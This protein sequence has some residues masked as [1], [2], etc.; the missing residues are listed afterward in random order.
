MRRTATLIAVLFASL[1]LAQTPPPEVE[2]IDGFQAYGTQAN[3][4]GWIDN[5][6][7]QPR[8]EAQGLYKTWPDPI[9]KKNPNV[10]YGTKQSSGKPEGS[11]PRIGTFSTHAP[12]TFS[13]RGRF[14]YRGRL[15]RTSDDTR[16]GLTF[17]SS[18]P[19]SDS[20]YLIGLWSTPAGKLTMQLFGFGAGSISG[21]VDSNVS[22]DV[23]KWY[24]FVIE[25]D[26]ADNSTKIRARFWP[27]G[28]TEPQTFSIDAVDAASSRLTSGRIGIWSA[29]KGEAYVDDLFAK[30]PVD[31]TAPLISILESGTPL[32]D[33]TVF[34]RDATPE[35]KVT[36]DLSA[37]NFTATL[38]GA[39]YTSLTPVTT[40]RWH[41]LLV[42]ASDSAGNA[43]ETERKF[44]VDKTPPVVS[45]LESGNA[46]PANFYFN[47]D[48]VIT[49]TVVD[50]SN[51]V[52]SATIDGQPYTPGLAYGIEG[53]HQLS[54]TAVDEAG[55]TT[56][57]G[58]F[59]FTIDKTAPVLTFTSH[60]NGAV[61]T[62][63]QAIV[64]GGSDDAVTVTLGGTPATVDATAKT[65]TGPVALLEGANT[66]V[67]TGTDRAGNTGTATLSLAVDT[68]APE[69]TITTPAADACVDA[70]TITVSGTV[71]EGR[72]DFVRVNGVNA[73][74][75]GGAWTASIP[76]TEGKLLIT[77]EARDTTGHTASRSRG[78]IVD[79]TAP[80]I[81]V[82]AGGAPFT[83]TLTNRAVSLFVRATD[84]DPNVTVTATLDG[85]A[86]T[87]G[88]SVDGEGAHK[89]VVKATDC[90]GHATEKTVEFTIDLT[91]PSIREFQPANGGTV[92]TTPNA[93]AAKTDTDVATVTVDATS[94]S[95][96]PGA[97]G[98]FTIAGVPFAE[99]TNRFTL[100][101]T[102][103]AG[104]SASVAYSVVVRTNAPAVEIRESGLPIVN[105]TLYNRAITPVLRAMPDAP[106]RAT[107]N[108]A[109][110]TSGTTITADGEYRI[111]ATAT[112]NLGHSG[113]A[114]ATFTIDRTPPAVTIASPAN[115]AVIRSDRVE[116]RGT[117][118]GA[119]AATINGAP[120]TIG[121][122]GSFAV[123]LPLDYGAN[124][125]F[126]AARDAAGNNGRADVTVL[127]DDAGAG[128][129][130]TYPADRSITNRRSTDVAGRLLTAGR[131]TTVTIGTQSVPVDAPGGFRLTGYALTEGENTIT[132]TA[133]ASNGL[134]TSA[135]THVTADFTPPSL[136]ILESSQPLSDG[137]RF[138]TRAAISL[139]ASDAGGSV[140]TELTIDGTVAAAPSS[141]TA[142]GGH[143]VV[144]TARD[145]AGNQS[146]AERMFFIGAATATADCKLEGFD[147]T[148]NA[149]VLSSS[150]TIVGRS[151]G[152]I[153]VKANGVP[154]VVADG[155]F[156]ATVELPNE[157]TNVVTVNCTD[158]NGTPTG[159]PA[160]LTLQRV[161]GDPSININT[162]AEGF[163]TSQ[164]TIAVSGTVGPGVTSAD[165][166]GVAA[167]ITGT[168]FT[169]PT[170]RLA[171]G[172]NII[173]A[174]GR[175]AAGRTAT[176]SR[177]GVYEKDAPSIAISTPTANA[178]TGVNRITVSGTY[179][180]IDPASIV[181]TNLSGNQTRPANAERFSDT[182]GAF[183]AIDVPLSSGDQTL[184]VSG[185]DRLNREATATVVVKLVAGSPGIS[186]TSPASQSWF[187]PGSNTFTV[188]GTF[189]AEAGALVDVN[190]NGATISGSSYTATATFSPVSGATTPV[191]A[192]VT[193]P[194]GTSAATVI[195]VTRLNDAPKV[196]E[197]FPAQNATEVDAGA[198]LLVLFS[199]P[200][201]VA[202]LSGGFRLED[203]NGAPVS[204]S[205]YLD[206]DVLTFA[207]STLLA[208]GGRYTMRVNG[209]AKNLAGTAVAEAYASSFTVASSAPSTPPNVDPV[210][211]AVCGQS[212]SVTGTAAPGA[213]VRLE[214]GTLVLTTSADSHGRFTF[215]YPMSGQSGFTVVRVRVVG[216]DGS[217][218]PAAEL[219][220]RVD[221]SGPQVLN[222][223]FDRT[224]N[225]LTISFSEA[226]DASTV[227]VGGA[228]IVLTLGDGTTVAGTTSVAG[229]S[230]TV[231]PASDLTQ[232]AFTLTVGTQIEDTTGNKLT[233]PYTQEFT[234]AGGQPETGDGSGF[235]SGEVYDATTGRPLPGVTIAVDVA[236]PAPVTTTTDARGRYLARLPEGAHTI[237]AAHAGYTSVFRE[238]IV[239]AGAGV[240]P[241]DIRL[242]HRGPSQTSTGA[243]LALTHGGD[244]GIT[245]K[246]DLAVPSA[247]SGAK[248]TLT[249]ISAQALTG[250]LPLGWSPI[251]SAEVQLEN[252]PSLSA[253]TLT[254]HTPAGAV[255]SAA[256]NLTAVHYD[257][258]RDEWRVLASSVNV[259][260]DGR[261]SFPIPG[262]GA[263]AL[264]YSDK[265]PGLTPPPLPVVGD[266]LQG[267]P[268]AP[269][270]APEL[271]ERD[272]KLDPAIVVPT[273]RTVATLRI[274]GAGEA[275]FPSGTAVQA[276]IDEELRLADGSRL[277]D[278]P[279]AT[280]LLLYRNLSGDLGIADF[281]LAPSAKAAQVILEVGFDHI[282]ILPYPGRLDRGTLI[283]SEGGRVPADDK[284]AIEIPTGAVPEPLRATATSLNASDLAAVGNIAGFRVVGGFQLTLQRAVQPAP[285]DLDGDGQPDAIAGVE[286]FVPARA[287]FSVDAAKMPAPNAQVILAE[288]LDQT[289]YGRIVRLA[290]PMM[291]VDPSQ[292]AT[293]AIRFTTR[294]ID[295]SA[296]PVDGVVREGRYIVLAADAPIAFATGTVRMRDLTGRLLSDARVI[297]NPLGVHELTRTNGIYNVPV[298]A[299]P[300]AP[301]TLVPRHTTTGDGATYT[302]AAQV[303][304]DA[305]VRVDLLLVPQPPVLGNVTIFKG[306]PPSQ[307]ALTFGTVTRDVAL[308]TNI[309]AAF[310]PAIDPASV[311]N[312]SITVVNAIT[313]KTVSGRA[314]SEGTTGVIWTLTA[315]ERFEPN[316]AYSVVI[317]QSI[318]GTNGATLA[319]SASF[320][321]AT[322]A[323]FVNTQIRRER[324]RIT[325]PNEAGISRITGDAGALPA[326]WQ[327]V[328]TRRVRDFFVR[329]Q[330]TA[331]SDGS[332]SFLIGD[333]DVRDR[334]TTGD[335]IDLQV[336]NTN[337][338]LAGIYALTP[339]VT[340]DGKGF[341][342]PAGAAVTFTSPEGITVN[343][344]EGAFD[345]P[346]IVTVNSAQKAEFLDIPE[347]EAENN[348][349]TSV[350]I[351]FEGFAN[352]PL[353]VEVAVP[354]GLNTTGRD[355]ILAWKGMSVRGPRLAVVD[356]MQVKDGKFTTVLDEETQNAKIG[357]TNLKTGT[358]STLVGRQARDYMLRLIRGGRYMV[359]DIKVPVGGSVGWGVMEG[360]QTGYDLM[361]DI[362]WSYYDPYVHNFERGGRIIPVITGR[363]FTV[364]GIDRATG[365]QAFQRAYDPIPVGEPGEIATIPTPQQNDSG[366][367]P[368]FGSPFRVEILDLD[369][370]DIEIRTVR[371]FSVTVAND[372]VVVSPSDDP[373]DSELHVQLLNVKQGTSVSGTAGG[374]L[375]IGAKLGDRIVLLIE[376][377]DVDASHPV[378]IVLNEAIF[379]GENPS[380]DGAVDAFLHTQLKLE[381]A[382]EPASGGQPNYTDITAHARFTVDSGEKRINII[383]PG[384]LQREAVYRLTLKGTLTDATTEGAG[385]KLGAGTVP[386]ANNNLVAV[387]GGAD[388]PLIFHV[389]KPEGEIGSFMAADTG[390]IRG[391]AMHGNA[392][393]VAALDGGLRTFDMSNPAAINGTAPQLSHIGPPNT[394]YK[395]MAVQVDRH[396]RVVTTADLNIVGVMLTY[397]VEDLVAGA[398][399]QQ[400]KASS[401][402][403]WKLGYSSMIGLPSNTILSDR[404]ESIPFRVK[405]VNQDD[406]TDFAD[407]QLFV[408]GTGASETADF[409]IE[410][411]KSY[412]VTVPFSNDTYNYQRITIENPDLDMSWS[413]DA[414][415]GGSATLKN[416]LA[417]PTDKLR[418]VKNRRAYA[419]VAHLGYGVGVYDINAMESNRY[420]GTTQANRYKEQH[421]LGNG[422]VGRECGIEPPIW[423]IGENY[424]N[425]DVEV[426]G[427]PSGDLYIFA[428]HPSK[429]VLDYRVHLSGSAAGTPS[430]DATCDQ[431]GET[432]LLFRTFPPGNEAP[433]MQALRN[434]I[435][436]PNMHTMSM[437]QVHWSVTA[438]ENTRGIRGT[439]RDLPA[440]RDY[441]LVAALDYGIVVVET[442]GDPFFTP[443]FPLD[444]YHI[445]DVIWIPGGAVGLR[446]MQDSNTA[447]VTDKNGRVLLVDLSRIDERFDADGNYVEGLF[448]TAAKAIAGTP[449]DP[450]EIG[451]DD[452][453]IIWKSEPGLT[454]GSQ[455][456]IFDASTGIIYGANMAARVVKA[457]SAVDPVVKMK[458]N[459]GNGL[460]EV[461]GVIPLGV[462]IPD[463]LKTTIDGL[464]AGKPAPCK[465][466]ASMGAFRLEVGLPG[467]LLNS[468]PNNE[469]WMA[470]ESERIAGAITEQTPNGFPRAHLRRKRRDGTSE[471]GDR[472]ATNFKFKR[473]VPDALASQLK[474][475]RGYNRYM[476][477]W[478]VAV[479]DPRASEQYNWNGASKE[480]K[481][482]AGCYACERPEFLK[483]KTESDGIY[484]LYT[485][486]R[487]L[488]VRPELAG[489]GDDTV[490][491]G[492]EY[493]YLGKQKRMSGLFTTIMADT[494]RPTE[495]LTAGQN[496]PVATGMIAETIFLHSG[497]LHSATTDLNVGGRAGTELLVERTYRSRTMG[498]SVF[499]QGWD[500]A[501]LRRLRAL[502]NGDVE[503]R[504]GSDVWTFK[505]VNGDY[506]APEGLFL[507]LARTGRGW[508]IIDQ[509][510]RVTDFDDLGRIT[511][512]TDEFYDPSAPGSGN[513]IRYVY[514]ETGRLAQVVDPVQRATKFTYWKESEAGASG[515]FPGMIRQV[516]DWRDRK[517]DYEY[518]SA[519]GTLTKVKLAEVQNVSGGRPAVAY[520]YGPGGGGFNDVL[521]M[522][523]NLARITAPHEV[524]SG[525]GPRLEFTYDPSSGFK[526]DRLLAQKWGTGE[527]ASFNYNG[528]TSVSTTDTLGQ[529]RTYSLTQQ[530]TNPYADRAHILSITETAVRTSTAPFGQLPGSISPGVPPAGSQDRT[531]RFTY[532]PG[533]NYATA[534]LD[535]VRSTTFTWKNVEPEAPGYVMTG[536]NTTGGAAPPVAQTIAYQA[537]ANLATFISSMT[538]NGLKIDSPEP[539]RNNKNTS[540]NNDQIN[541]TEKFDASG[542]LTTIA[543]SGGTDAS[544][545]GSS[546][547]ITYAPATDSPHR[548]ALPTSIVDGGL[549][550]K[551]DYPS[552]TKTVETDARGTVT[553]IEYDKWQRPIHMSASGGIDEKWEYDA[554]GK[555]RKHTRKQG[556]DDVTTTYTYDIM[557]RQTSESVTG[558]ADVG[559]ATTTIQYNGRT[560][561]T[562][563][564]SGAVT[565]M[566]V[567][568]LGRPIGRELTTGGSP[569]VAHYTHDLEDNVVAESDLLTATA[570]AY[571]AQGN[572]TGVLS[573]DG[574]RTVATIDAM[575]NPLTIE[576]RDASGSVLRSWTMQYAGG[577]LR[578]VTR[579]AGS[580]ST[581]MEVA[582]D[583]AGRT[584]GVSAG[585][586]AQRTE[587]DA[588]GRVQS[589]A[590]GA[591][592]AT[593]I[594]QIFEQAQA[595][596]HSGRLPQK[597]Q[598]TEKGGGSYSMAMQYNT[599]GEAV[600]Q[601]LGSLSWTKQY[602]QMGNVTASSSPQR[603]THTY[604]YDSQG[605]M[606][607]ETLPGGA[608]TTFGYNAAGTMNSYT[609]PSSEV[610]A[611]QTDLIGRATQRTYRDGTTE[612]IVWE[613]SRVK[614]ITDRQGRLQTFEYNAKGQIERTTGGSGVVLD[615][616]TYDPAGRIT[617]WKTPDAVV[618]YD[619]YDGE[620]RAGKTTQSRYRGGT[621][622]DQYEQRHTYNE[623]GER[624]SFTMPTYSGFSSANAWTRSVTQQHDAMGNLIGIERQMSGGA[625]SGSLLQA[626][627]RNANRPD[628]RVVTTV[629]GS[630]IVR[631]Y[632]Y[633]S[634]TGLPNK[635]EVKSGGLT[636]AGSFVTWDGIQ[637]S[638]A[639]L[640]GVSGG[641]RAD[642]WTYDGRGRLTATSL[643]RDGGSTPDGADLNSADFRSAL[644]RTKTTPVDPPSLL[645]SEAPGHKIASMQRGS[646]AEAFSFNGG[647]RSEDGQF[648]YEYDLK[649]RLSV[650]T[651]KSASPRR[652][653]YFY[654]G[655]DRMV[656]RRAEYA[657]ATS[658]PTETDWKLE[659]RFE[660][661][662]ADALPPDA[663]FV[664]DPVDDQLVAIYKAGASQNPQ[665][666]E[667]GGLVRQI[668]HGGAR[669]DDPLEVA[670]A[671]G[672]APNGVARLYPIYDEGGAG[673][674]DAILNEQG[675]IVSRSVEG[676]PYGEDEAVLKGSAVDRVSV[677]ARR[678]PDGKITA[679]DVLLRS[680]EH[681][682]PSTL[683]AG[684]RLA[685]IDAAGKVVRAATNA[686]SLINSA[687]VQWSLTE[688]EWNTLVSTEPVVVDGQ[689][690]TPSALSI[691]VTKD[692][693]AEAWSSA[694]PFLAAPAW[695]VATKPV[696]T[697][698][699]LPLE[700]RESLANLSQ[701]LAALPADEQQTTALY[702]V[703]SLYAL[704]TPRMAGSPI[705][706]PVTLIVSS[707]FHA[708]PFLDPMTG[709]SYVRARW[710][711]PRTGTW[712]TPDPR[713]Y[714]D[715]P[716]LYAYA[717]NDPINKNDPTGEAWGFAVD[718]A[719]A[720][721]D[722]YQYA[723]GGIDGKEYAMRMALT[724]ASVLAN[725]ATGGMGGGVLV[726]A[727]SMAGRAGR[728]VR[729]VLR[730]SVIVNRVD[731]AVTVAQ[732]AIS[733]HEAVV[734]GDY[735][736]GGVSAAQLALTALGAKRGRNVRGQA[737]SNRTPAAA[738]N[739]GE[740][741]AGKIERARNAQL[742]PG[743]GG[744]DKYRITRLK[745]G[746]L[747][748]G[749]FPGQGQWYTD[750]AT[751]K[752]S[753]LNQKDYHD[754]VQVDMRPGKYPPR[755]RI[756]AY[757][758]KEDIEVPAGLTRANRQHGGGGGF[759]YFIESYADV[760]EP[761]RVFNMKK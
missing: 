176:A 152:A 601:T 459:L 596:G 191:V 166:N 476:S 61:L 327:A 624:T 737:V 107:L 179:T 697:S 730:A 310:T 296:L 121:D 540:A 744:Q 610:T 230:V 294:S 512:E 461:G 140:T 739:L 685:V 494:I 142:A 483:T 200:M 666:D 35:V 478:I 651:Q 45:A 600:A 692:A 755:D 710:F 649:G 252:A 295:R 104:N 141:V 584:T 592:S 578:S 33:G 551:L 39:P 165:V 158:A 117:V 202:S 375:S 175:N 188:T 384:A 568:S 535:G 426:R 678:D 688:A 275:K 587:F 316:T 129:I 22:V 239:P 505:Y 7:G 325:I 542:Q 217:L 632:G 89:L 608:S 8:P 255:T 410:D 429:G 3:P 171:D 382:P 593:S 363:P 400:S 514:D 511:L 544:S 77:V 256:Q 560:I 241:I 700:V 151:G 699:L 422:I 671:D 558:V 2:F 321:F 715:S 743:Y 390:V 582:W 38:N 26:D 139:D 105:G 672:T 623:H 43:S 70:A 597:M 635:M 262:A 599:L 423:A 661:I 131:G 315:G 652:V 418:I 244:T 266:V 636:V 10:V 250:L 15:L 240:I 282:R 201:D 447:V 53:T 625:G 380:D 521:E 193:E 308:T 124:A 659:D 414:T 591:G 449:S 633:D 126:I 9:D 356:M 21:T 520:E 108:G 759:Q 81:E 144:A 723:T 680:T 734:H 588:A 280:D 417:R 58:P 299:K 729:T 725:V 404:P 36:D 434:A 306:D 717:A 67:A 68:R 523:T 195:F 689:T 112:D 283:G 88:T 704:G 531:Y 342:A 5:S 662:A 411:L 130:L 577:R 211:S 29:V 691:A 554:T 378:S 328:A 728:V 314:A 424:I 643:A 457:V 492:T 277:L 24:R 614:S 677:S 428:N 273:G 376:Q 495:V 646:A 396:G 271:V 522:R 420:P 455:P 696:Y 351:D 161:T 694:Q 34:K 237:S 267:V 318:R 246:V 313:G 178:T 357:V 274:E 391:M 387:G 183:A 519:S 162:P 372:N 163:V 364:Y 331:A 180:N 543:G 687:T 322:V 285:Q 674:L 563:H 539:S 640:L 248:V 641:A 473:V 207:P 12:K 489:L 436:S 73:T 444:D 373:L 654:S 278:P 389:R 626:D 334:V 84:T 355:F 349:A 634:G 366:P 44:L 14:E 561:V 707:S 164:E 251:A 615:E 290:A 746:Q 87:S 245:R 145:R 553:T 581:T 446:V 631:D 189:T 106:V 748:Y 413:A 507:K 733:L 607:R 451:A 49:A 574:T 460:T 235:I 465:E 534:S 491:E 663:T 186:I 16:I 604:S 732:T 374:S 665:I 169:V 585:G 311:T 493:E 480:K 377:K 66:I 116:V 214:S 198:L 320:S 693:R 549:L 502:P 415:I 682:A 532:G 155:S 408:A 518:Q 482:E 37:V 756:Q 128:I 218:S 749:A 95:A 258:V 509:Q 416:V 212:M 222:A 409:P 210:G 323:V 621:L 172:L 742:Y 52:V 353:D 51:T 524:L 28:S 226:L 298:P 386:A 481:A 18:Y 190:G 432:G 503:Y 533:G 702:D 516:T 761:V 716:N 681:F 627:Y 317:S 545:A 639:Q 101:A 466:N 233:T 80:A 727:A 354:P 260:G 394:I 407:R 736:R 194:D 56:T 527:T 103:R 269:A 463:H 713:G 712:L 477:P 433:R 412:N 90:A 720:A 555:L 97:G 136:T 442:T 629:T 618:D 361:W 63:A 332:F 362:F 297:A 1:A 385:L 557:G 653:K 343:V 575:G 30:S 620:G 156:S 405:I 231:T 616:Y 281:H 541:E 196:V 673:S 42:R 203:A 431:R 648:I 606:K 146:R 718:I 91:A 346:T 547:T 74:V 4:P 751:I 259:A 583:G 303:D 398:T 326:G 506:K 655:D 174:H 468:M 393:M 714:V 75:T 754:L 441:L 137:A 586:R 504:D 234:L 456:P 119:V 265:A 638:R 173:V 11:N 552:A 153:G 305:V 181:V 686:P 13:A 706:N 302:H 430:N 132:A 443:P 177:R 261:A 656:G 133:T 472:A 589:T 370:E 538:A 445:A 341:V 160:T 556:S 168:T 47:R 550:T 40:E 59:T 264:V 185:R 257:A 69:L 487:Y 427:D 223:A 324:I 499:G 572:L 498:G 32:A 138:A 760:L 435:G 335:L 184:R 309:R 213:R 647:E 365:L 726:R 738:A 753:K 462:A 657:G 360:L 135:S 709:K 123:E 467:G 741:R 628:R 78:V 611:T 301:F 668:I 46:F 438:E 450:N 642:E 452:P 225:K 719:F 485:N 566:I 199:Q 293:P 690:L 115:D 276:Y 82:T 125:I 286:L 48:V 147:P 698:A 192:R 368:V 220:V 208:K 679:V 517:I 705:G 388:L 238:I 167:T 529:A 562:N 352:K 19:Q 86:Y 464:C 525:G 72:L 149:V 644:M 263:Y 454:A 576:E 62:A 224:V 54:L 703:P 96:T 669:Y 401:I 458:V 683:A 637:K 569:I 79:R 369:V 664:W 27:E 406:T 395:T 528:P 573:S 236:S 658:N 580:Q 336:V 197:S 497:E 228:G 548:R 501:L 338:A 469:L 17:L 23:N 150:V 85:A 567:D 619:D 603:G 676:G 154:A 279:F 470:V 57:A 292:T 474:Y 288:L 605:S 219:T 650:V 64:I 289:P 448:P 159:T 205:L 249:A 367:Y 93:I 515:A 546:A 100:V 440:Q 740:R 339:F 345:T 300:A 747:I 684:V 526:R 350:N 344:P 667:N 496:P 76:A 752:K 439:L 92:G 348:Y 148:N 83:T 403:N 270:T 358:N 537:G 340:E 397:R 65:F 758:V 617:R 399:V 564:P 559:T 229:N 284:V 383:L 590:S 379:L 570:F 291:A 60:Q 304:P 206:K 71:A 102:D 579:T 508:S 670:A 312:E 484:E 333:D 711:D 701:W 216:S 122:G 490:F 319:R 110:Y 120:L 437:S 630:Q 41:T 113:S 287:T 114:E 510:W 337:G 232:R 571:D 330:A 595:S 513:L 660:V 486:G 594:S 329:Y 272:F 488:T 371:N 243:A 253:A 111:H 143:S 227:S 471:T 757:R 425:T 609:D 453:R 268:A 50:V 750:L 392:L 94:L 500:S 421:F 247:A 402:I 242:T 307:A 381:Q 55:W 695:A 530:P 221:C 735:T 20:Y 215:T 157:G 187:G 565:T 536:S 109:T 31:F 254:F 602:D 722:T 475:Q 731:N 359:L 613:G 708:H 98:S 25:V 134:Q 745:K 170:V 598:K 612:K 127:R 721:W 182:T 99:G 724:G 6:I 419:V 204:G 347:L 209:A 479:S 645:F 118:T 622:I 675:R